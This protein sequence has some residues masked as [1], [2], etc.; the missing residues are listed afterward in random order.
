MR[1]KGFMI[2]TSHN[3]LCSMYMQ[4]LVEPRPCSFSMYSSRTIQYK[5]Q[6]NTIRLH[7]LCILNMISDHTNKILYTKIIS[8][9]SK[10]IWLY[11][12]ILNRWKY[13]TSYHSS[14]IHNS[15]TIIN[16]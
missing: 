2:Y 10:V 6:E 15:H 5:M 13:K 4:M 1:N 14:S 16:D 11:F 3:N 9:M 7:V 8:I 12:R